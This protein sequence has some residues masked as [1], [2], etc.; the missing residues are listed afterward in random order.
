[1]TVG[2][3]MNA[4]REYPEEMHVAYP[5]REGH[6]YGYHLEPIDFIEVEDGK[7]LLS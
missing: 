5:E 2:E 4:L 7:L 3:L 6:A 1:M